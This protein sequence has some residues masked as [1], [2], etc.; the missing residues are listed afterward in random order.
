M[1]RGLEDPFGHEANQLPVEDLHIDL[2]ERL[3]ITNQR[4]FKKDQWSHQYGRA[5]YERSR[6]DIHPL[7]PPSPPSPQ[8]DAAARVRGW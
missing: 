4:I 3:W 6:T 8:E 2:N 5:D 7:P 1:A